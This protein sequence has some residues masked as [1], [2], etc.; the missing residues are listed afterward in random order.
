MIVRTLCGECSVGCGVRARLDPGRD[1]AIEG[2][3]VHPANAGALCER[4]LALGE[5]KA[6]AGRLLHPLVGGRRVGWDRAVAAITRRLADDRSGS[7]VAM[8]MA[9]DLLTEDYYAA[10]KLMKGFLGTA[11]IGLA[12]G[13]GG[14]IAAAHIAALGEDVT[15]ATYEDLEQADVLI[16]IGADIAS[17]HPILFDRIEAARAQNGLRLIRIGRSEPESRAAPDLG[18]PVR[19][20]TEST[21]LAGLLLHCRD[22]GLLDAAWLD[23]A[24]NASTHFWRDLRRGHDLWSVAQT[25]G[26]PPS[27]IRAFFD[28]VAAQSRLVSLFVPEDEDRPNRDLAA[29]ILNLHL[30]TGRIGRRGAAPMIIGRAGNGMGAREAGCLASDLAAHMDFAPDA[31]DRVARFWSAPSMARSPGLAGEPLVEAIRRGEIDILWLFGGA[32]LDD[33]LMR[34]AIALSPF[35]IMATDRLDPDLAHHIDI[36]LPAVAGLERN[37]TMTSADR[38]ISRHRP[39]LTPPGEARAPWWMVM[40]VANAMGWGSAFPYEHPADIYREHARLAAY[41]NDGARLFD[42]RRHASVSNPAYDELTP[43]RWGGAPFDDGHFPTPDGRA[44]L[45]PS[46]L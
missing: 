10:N 28:R 19:P 31:V 21:L 1:L 15:P 39:V 46:W 26:L 22:A 2:D 11:H 33:P 34:Q 3:T 18:L 43:W 25:C 4:G 29:A 6:L 12:H 45:V 20:G 14:G 16:Q 40:K 38:L 41:Q 7:R 30:A 24:V 23:Q 37:G 32:S 5:E 27:A 9:G 36:V 8:Q 13:E 42:L 17:T 44:R 35:T